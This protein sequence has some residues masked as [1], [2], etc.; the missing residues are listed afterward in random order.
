MPFKMP[1][2]ALIPLLILAV[3]GIFLL[4]DGITGFVTK[5][6]CQGPSCSDSQLSLD[7]I[8]LGG[9]LLF[10]AVAGHIALS[11]KK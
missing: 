8:Y 5:D 4:D 6:S 11:K 1:A 10:L 7:G 3:M 9:I 2:K